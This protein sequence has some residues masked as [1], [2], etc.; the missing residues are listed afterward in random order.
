MFKKSKHGKENYGDTIDLEINAC[1]AQDCT[2]LIPASIQNEEQ[3]ESYEELYPYI[4]LAKPKND[5]E[6]FI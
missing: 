6:D 5:E 1:S 4:P 2:G 3:I